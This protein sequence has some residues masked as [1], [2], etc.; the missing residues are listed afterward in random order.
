[1]CQKF[2]PRDSA[3]P[4]VIFAFVVLNGFTALCIA[5]DAPT[6]PTNPTMFGLSKV[7]S[8]EL[9]M[10][11]DEYEGMQPPPGPGFGP[12]GAPPPAAQAPR[13]PGKKRESERNLFGTEFPWAHCD[14]SI[15]G[16]TISNVG[17]RYAG[18][19]TYFAS[20]QGLKRPLQLEFNRFVEQEFEGLT[21]L[22]L[23][24]MPMDPAKGREVLAL[25]IFHDFGVPTPRGGFVEVTLTVRGR[26]D[27]EFL[28]LYAS[29][30]T[31]DMRFLKNHFE[32]DGGTLMKPFQDRSPNRPRTRLNE[33]WRLHV[34]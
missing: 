16:K 11:V 6:R 21:S 13:N 20:S 32:T 30:E 19:I 34:W 2:R 10:T 33:S 9:T 1:M 27:K 22:Q 7:A 18:E 23:H 3:V 25:S 26:F 15:D 12:P 31:V 8:I 4:L 5:A 14:L 17:I 28:G 24:S 29:I